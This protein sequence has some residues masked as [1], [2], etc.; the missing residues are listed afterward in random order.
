MH[1]RRILLPQW[2]P[3]PKPPD[4]YDAT[5]QLVLPV[6]SLKP[7]L[8]LAHSIPLAGHKS[9]PGIFRDVYVYCCSCTRRGKTKA[10]FVPLPIIDVP[11]MP[12]T[13]FHSTSGKRYILVICNYATHYPEAIPLRSI[14][15]NPIASELVK[16]FARV[17]V[18]DE[19][20]TDQWTNFTSQLLQEVYN[21]LPAKQMAWL[22]TH[23]QINQDSNVRRKKLG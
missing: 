1:Y 19:I 9:H 12:W 10:P 20:L 2:S 6:Q 22:Q 17:G 13:L 11:F 5:E 16:L 4:I 21:S 7:V 3:L 8:H 18:P 14:E 23:T 15:A